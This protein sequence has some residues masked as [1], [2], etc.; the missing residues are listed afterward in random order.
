MGPVNTSCEFSAARRQKRPVVVAGGS[1][2]WH[3]ER[4]LVLHAG[5]SSEFECAR[6]ELAEETSLVVELDRIVYIQEYVEPH[7]HFRKFFIL[8]QRVRWGA[9]YRQ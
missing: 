3:P 1:S 8:M 5:T 7:Y 9:D 4:C 2:W 6:R